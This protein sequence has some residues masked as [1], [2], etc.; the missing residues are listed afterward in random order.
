MARRILT[1]DETY[2]VIS[3]YLED[4]LDCVRKGFADYVQINEFKNTIDV[5]SE[6]EIR[7]RAGII[8]DR[9][10][11]RLANKFGDNPEIKVGVWNQIFA[12]KFADLIFLRNKK[13]RK[14]GKVSSYRTP[15]H[16][17]FLRQALIEGFPDE[18]TFVIGGYIPNDAYTELKGIYLGCWGPDGLEWFTKVGEYIVE[19]G[20]IIFPEFTEEEATKKRTKIKDASEQSTTKKRT[21][22]KGKPKTGEDEKTGTGNA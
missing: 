17:S 21:K 5:Y 6:F 1:F 4:Y 15:Q 8:H 7:T 16:K 13:F 10:C 18:P 2:S 9:I 14:S 22:V 3:P 20:R 19:Q 12:L 11:G